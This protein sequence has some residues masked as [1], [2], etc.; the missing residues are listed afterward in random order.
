[1]GR[2]PQAFVQLGFRTAYALVSHKIGANRISARYDTFRTDDRD[3]SFAETNTEHGHAWT[4]AFLHDLSDRARIGIEYVTLTAP[5]PAAAES[6][7]DPNTDGR[8]VS[9]ELRYRY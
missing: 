9:V 6:G 4:V 1:M 2:P 5:R 8:S 3:H 7:F